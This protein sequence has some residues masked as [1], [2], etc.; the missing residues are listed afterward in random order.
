MK[1]KYH[2]EGCNLRGE[3]AIPGDKSISHRA[4]MFGAIASGRTEVTNFLFCEDCLKTWE[5]LRQLGVTIEKNGKSVHV[6]G[7]SWLKF[8]KP[9]K[10]LYVGNSGT[11]IRLMMGL[12]ASRPFMTTFIGDESISKRPMKRVSEPLQLMGARIIGR[13]N[14]NLVPLTVVGNNLRAIQYELKVASAQVKS[15]ILLAGLQARGETTIIEPMQTRDHTENMIAQFGGQISRRNN[16][17]TVKGGAELSGCVVAVPGDISTAIFWI[18]AAIITK[19]SCVTLTNVGLNPTRTGAIE[20]MQAMGAN[21]KVDLQPS[22]NEPIGNITVTSS[23]L[24]GVII[25]G[26]IIPRLIDEL[27]LIALLATQAVGVTVVRN[28]E[29]MRVKESDRILATVTMLKRLGANIVEN[30]DGFIVKGK[31]KLH[32]ACVDSFSDHRIAMM[33]V[34]ASLITSSPITLENSDIVNI[35]YPQFFTHLVHLINCN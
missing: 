31:T 32:G 18:V 12:V 8:V 27:S 23:Q 35:S 16:T 7:K 13:D 33:L 28:A 10:K 29:E 3:I 17:V 19:N 14:S 11:T 30:K 4:L 20:I 22:I 21:I 1:E 5:C 2:F 34:I 15:A 24:T 25:E 26:N 6:I 9:R